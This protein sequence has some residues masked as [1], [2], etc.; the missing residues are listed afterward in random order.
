MLILSASSVIVNILTGTYSTISTFMSLYDYLAII[1]LMALESASLPIPSEIILPLAGHF[2]RTGN[3]NIILAIVASMVGTVIGISVDYWI[4][5][6][7]EKDVVYKHLH[8]FKINKSSL[9]AFD[10]WF[11]KNGAFTVFVSRMLPVV[12]GLISFPAGFAKM[13][14]KNFYLYSLIG[15]LIWNTALIIFGYYALSI[16][17]VQ[18][19]FAVL[20]VFAIVLYF[21][22][23]AGM[24]K[25]KG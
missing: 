18:I 7:I 23:R 16:S 4:A 10:G 21:V 20:A 15:A 1:V 25:I 22:Y 17:N 5:Y 13:N 12:R 19:M 24:K 3:L 14:L 2:V 8:T 11:A 9:E 6:F